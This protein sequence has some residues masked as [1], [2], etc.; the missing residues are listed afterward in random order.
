MCGIAGVITKKGFKVEDVLSTLNHRGPDS[1]GFYEY[2]DLTLFHSRLS[3]LDLS[4]NGNQPMISEDENYV[5]VFNGEIYNHLDL[6]KKINHKFKSTCDTETILSLFQEFGPDFLNELNGIFSLAIFDKIKNELI[7]ARDHFGVKPLY[8]YQ[9]ENSFIFSSEIKTFL[10]FD[11][12]RSI[13]IQSISNYITFLWSPGESTPFKNVKKLLPGTFYNLKVNDPTK[14]E[15]IKFFEVASKV[16][17]V[18]YSEEEAINLLEK[19]IVNAV[20]RQLLSD[21][22]V[23]FFLSGG[24]DSSLI[25]AIAN[26]ISD[27]KLECFTLNDTNSYNNLEDFQSDLFYAKKVSNYLGVNLNIVDAEVD[28]LDDLDK[29][30]WFLDEPQADPACIH[31]RNIAELARKK[32]IKVL[33][34][35]TAG[36]DLFSGYRRH[37]A[38]NYEPLF[39]NVPK[40]IFKFL[41]YIAKI[42]GNKSPKF[43]RINKFLQYSDALQ[44]Y[45]ISGYFSWLN[46][47][48]LK[49]IIKDEFIN[50]I[51]DPLDYFNN[52]LSNNDNR[53]D[54][55]DDM[56]I[57]ELK[58][59][60][61][62]HNLNYT[63]KMGMSHGVEIRV[64]FLDRELYEFSRVL[65]S[66]FK[67]KNGE[68]KYILKKVAE[69]YLPKEVIYR[70]KTGF[71]SPVR[72]WIKKDLKIKL[73]ETI[74]T[75]KNLSKI[76]KKDELN[77]IIHLNNIGKLDL[78]YP[79]LSILVIDSWMKQ[80]LDK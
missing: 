75:S 32:N 80:F 79:L 72:N 36:D 19:K 44:D 9:D 29:M 77:K 39:M 22:P 31:V 62:D 21:V 10:Q 34:G 4:E 15:C 35:G 42:A 55:L 57:L 11:I 49:K 6:R 56:L 78:S 63:D 33:I 23:G 43:R 30:V 76:F 50:Q 14:M 7:L 17:K 48:I 66:S 70:P 58:G 37:K 45:R 2:R 64:P 52:I 27:K 16:E 73:N 18:S 61:P 3:I 24:L 13:D 5:I 74:N 60:L 53:H 40:F 51:H 12:D 25:V 8:I 47:E 20:K 67:L 71:G 65:E 28:I 41:K 59:F 68:T 54:V 38:L 26:K 46:F 1:S 69:K